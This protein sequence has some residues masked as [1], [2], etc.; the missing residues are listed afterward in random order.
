[1]KRAG[2]AE[3][4][5]TLKD[6]RELLCAYGFVHDTDCYHEDIVCEPSYWLDGDRVNEHCVPKG[7]D[8]IMY[9]MYVHSDRPP[10]RYSESSVLRK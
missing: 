7:L 5:F 9:Q 1:M 6:G 2:L 10:F 8:T 4:R 3:V